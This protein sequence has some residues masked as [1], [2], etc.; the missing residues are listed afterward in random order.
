MR[1]GSLF[2]VCTLLPILASPTKSQSDGA[3]RKVRISV[4]SLVTNSLIVLL[5][6]GIALI[7]FLR[8]SRFAAGFSALLQTNRANVS[9]PLPKVDARSLAPGS[10]YPGVILVLPPKSRE[11]IVPCSCPPYAVRQ[12]SSQAGDHSL[13]WRILVFQETGSTPKGRCADRSRRSHKSEYSLHRLSTVIDGGSPG[14][15]DSHKNGLLQRH[16]SSESEMPTTVRVRS[17]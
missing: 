3:N 16:S 9:G 7:P 5:F 10:Y 6:T 13:R 17:S 11:E 15:G 1:A 4:R 2:A 12:R 14:Y 8:R